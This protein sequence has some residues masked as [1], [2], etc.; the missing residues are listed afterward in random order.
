VGGC[1]KISEENFQ[2]APG[3]GEQP[4]TGHPCIRVILA[5][6]GV[7]DLGMVDLGHV[8]VALGCRGDGQQGFK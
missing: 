5:D 7:F 2:K 6:Q 3:A 8:E 1:D 4:G